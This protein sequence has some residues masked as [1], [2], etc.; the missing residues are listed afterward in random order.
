MD[1]R[2]RQLVLFHPAH[3]QLGAKDGARTAADALDRPGARRSRSSS[4]VL[5]HR[6]C[7]DR[8]TARSRLR[9]RRAASCLHPRR[10]RPGDEVI[11]P[12]FTCTA[13]NIPLLYIGAKPVF[14]DVQPDTLNID[15]RARATSSSPNGPAPSSASTTAGCPATW[16][17]FTQIADDAG[18]P[19]IEDA[20]HAVGASYQGQQHRLDLRV[21]D[22]LVPGDQAHHDRRRRHARARKSMARYS[23]RRSGVRWFGIDREGK[24]KGNL[25]ERHLGGRLQVPDDRHRRRHGPR[26]SRGVGRA[27]AHIAA[28]SS[29]STSGARGRAGLSVVGG[30]YADRVHAAWLCTVFAERRVDLQRKLREHRS[31][32]TRSTTATIATRCSATFA[33]RSRT[34]TRSRTTTSCC[35][36]TPT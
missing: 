19:M 13:T 8:A 7:D 9:H 18:V 17:S 32:R 24:Q 2:G 26:A 31:S 15:P 5:R 14:A 35:R 16:T 4:R 6:F 25:G 27:S 3:Q 30:G 23:P 28:T 36:C 34:W 11:T 1:E 10:D 20:A 21:H 22:V 33:V 29:R 12:L